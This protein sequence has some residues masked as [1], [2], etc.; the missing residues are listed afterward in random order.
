MTCCFA[1]IEKGNK[2]GARSGENASEIEQT[3]R[4]QILLLH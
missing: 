2:V 4:V 3:N 1:V